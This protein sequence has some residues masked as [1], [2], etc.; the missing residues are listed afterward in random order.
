SKPPRYFAYVLA[1]QGQP[2]WADLGEAAIIDRAVDA[3]RKALRD[4]K[5]TDV[6]QL[7][8]ELDEMV[9]RP[10]RSLLGNTQGE[11]RRLLVAPDGS[12][13][14]IPFAALVDER[15][16]YLVERY[17]ISYLT[18]GRD[19]LRF[20]TSQQ[21]KNAPLVVANP[22]FGKVATVVSRGDQNAGNS[23]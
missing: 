4:P 20:E 19:L 3:W 12:L 21:N 14:L 2:K 10:V 8:R 1:A 16:Q 15:N 23:Q 5:R 17:T 13:N 18:S 11:T 22:L 9:M 6:K 7:A